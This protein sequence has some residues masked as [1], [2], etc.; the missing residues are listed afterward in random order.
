MRQVET[1]GELITSSGTYLLVTDLMDTYHI[2]H[3][4]HKFD[5]PDDQANQT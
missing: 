4:E 5:I 2:Q 3:F 1:A